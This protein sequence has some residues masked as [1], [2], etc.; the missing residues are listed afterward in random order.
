MTFPDEYTV[1][2]TSKDRGRW[3]DPYFMAQGCWDFAKNF[4][5]PA[6]YLKEYHPNYTTSGKTWEDYTNQDKWWQTPGYPCLF[7]WCLTELSSDGQNYTF[8]RNPYYWRVDRKQLPLLTRS[9]S[10]R[11]RQQTR[12]L[13][14]LQGK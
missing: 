7:A 14:C 2:W 9:T 13:N 4:M 1:V 5:K 8:T 10:D 11:G 6:H 3:I 12:I